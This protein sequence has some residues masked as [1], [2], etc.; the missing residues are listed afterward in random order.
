MLE[1]L[2][3]VFVTGLLTG[4]HC[5]AMCGSLVLSYVAG[6]MQD[7]RQVFLLQHLVYNGSRILSYGLVGAALGFP[8]SV[9]TIS[10]ASGNP[11]RKLKDLPVL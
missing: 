8:G 4:I 11:H 5:I 7:K 9:F 10:L 6:G 2:A 3:L 1:Y